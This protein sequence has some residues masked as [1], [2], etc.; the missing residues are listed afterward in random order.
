MLTSPHPQPNT[1]SSVP[2]LHRLITDLNTTKL[3]NINDYAGVS[4]TDLNNYLSA[5][6]LKHEYL[7]EIIACHVESDGTII[8]HKMVKYGN[9]KVV[10]EIA[11]QL[12]KWIDYNPK[13]GGR[14]TT[15][16]G[17]FVYNQGDNGAEVLMPDVAYTPREVDRRLNDKQIWSYKGEP[18]SPTFV[19]EIDVLEGSKS[20]FKQLDLKM[21]H[22]YFKKMNVKLGWL[23]DPEKKVMIV[24]NRDDS[25]EVRVSEDRSWRTLDGK[26]ILPGFVVEAA[27]LDAVL[28]QEEGS[29]DE[30]VVDVSCPRCG[31]KFDKDGLFMQHYEMHRKSNKKNKA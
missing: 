21:K 5:H 29:S 15:S 26:D 31:E 30:D 12:K 11:G 3:C 20:Q 8:P 28:A 10:F 27:D 13:F 25:G 18:F 17:A 2:N 24:Y 7:G 22:F 19:V 23:I 6:P 4:I 16:Q 14:G 1:A 9:E